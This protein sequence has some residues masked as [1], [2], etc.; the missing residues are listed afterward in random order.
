VRRRPF[1][2]RSGADRLFGQVRTSNPYVEPWVG[3]AADLLV[4]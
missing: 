3:T 1:G 2:I 4:A